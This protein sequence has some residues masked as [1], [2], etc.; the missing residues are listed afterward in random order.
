M[1]FRN[2]EALGVRDVRNVV[3]VGDTVSD[4]REGCA[5]ASARSAWRKAAR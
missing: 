4:I 2:L 1:V 5:P 3:K